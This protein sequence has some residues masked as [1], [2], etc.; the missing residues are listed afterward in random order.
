MIQRKVLHL[1]QA[2]IRPVHWA[3]FFT[4]IGFGLR[5]QKLDFQPL[6]G[7]EGW[8]FYF[9]TQPLSQLLALTAIDIHPPLYYILLKGWLFVVGLGAEEA[10]FLSVMIGTALIPV[11]GVMG[12]RLFTWRVGIVVAGVTSIM[13]LTIYYSQEV[14]MYGLV[15]L[16]G[17]MSIYFL[18]KTEYNQTLDRSHQLHQIAFIAT[19]AAALF[20]HYYAA[21]IVLALLLYTILTRLWRRQQHNLTLRSLFTALL[22]FIYIGLIYLPWIIYAG[23]RL[24]NYVENKRNVEGY[25]PLG[26]MRFFGDH[27]VAFS[28]GHL[29]TDVSPGYRWFAV[30]IFVVASVGFTATLYSK[31]RHSRLSYLYLFIPLLIGYLVNLFYPFTP[32]FFER[33]LLLAAPAY[34]LFIAIGIIWLWDR[35]HLLSGTIVAAIFGIVAVSLNGFY[36]VPRYP[37]EDYRPL[38]KDVAARATPEDT[39]LASYQWQL[40]FYQAYLP[41]PRPQIFVV[42]E[43][44]RGWS[45][46]AGGASQLAADLTTILNHSPRLW[47]PAYQA[48]GH[49]WEDEAETAIAQ[50]GYPALLQW[51]SPQIKLTLAGAPQAPLRQAPTANFGNRLTLLEAMVGN[52]QYEAGRDIVP[53]EL[54]WQKINN[55][56]SEYIVSLR[57]T[58]ATGRTWATRDSHPQAGQKLFT[59][60][61]VNDSL[62]DRHGLL[63]P[64]GAPPGDY[65]LWLSVRRVND[66]HPLDLLDEAGQPLGAELLLAEVELIAPHLPVGV[67]ALPVQTYTNATFEQ[68]V[69]LIGF[70][71]GHNPVKAGESVSLT[72]FWESLVDKP[73]SLMVSVELQ[74]SSGQS[75]VSHQQEPIWPATQWQKGTLLRDPHDFVLPPTLPPDDYH[76]V[77]SLFTPDHEMLDANGIHQLPLTTVT[78]IDRPH[79][80]AA[81]DPQI[82]LAVTFGEQAKLVGLGLPKTQV[83]PGDTVPLTLYWQ[84]LATMD[85]NWTVFVHLTDRDGKIISQQ[86]QIPGGGQFPTTSWVPNEYLVDN[87]SLLI[88]A[89]TPSSPQPYQLEI[90]LYDVTDF[91]RLPILEAGEIV[92]DHFTLES[93]PI[94]IE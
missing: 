7:D 77:V 74:D 9:A 66:A 48:G 60:M 85:K 94:F 79:N 5:L 40:G 22:P 20:T 91:S 92:S 19:T 53:V 25:I 51:Y 30:V 70:S 55:L 33:T 59:D 88:P 71:L 10:R 42:P 69:R 50:L 37:D 45:S 17:A 56:D 39:L 87:Y 13:P 61:A 93:W 63:T 58:D 15:T 36:T 82:E 41:S 49:I 86:D 46:Q 35:Y 80:F 11:M 76:L 65:R 3:L 43:W 68:Q 12:R 75:V 34:W 44:G 89:D 73:G 78:T 32:R 81:P 28:L 31:Y 90:G 18:I 6:W 54:V 2:R 4:L 27:F 24:V 72:L 1:V 83:A 26:F 47:F 52:E 64:A 62:V 84:A 57:L 67:A 29:P 8:S 21:L 14:R 16:L 23:S 38:L